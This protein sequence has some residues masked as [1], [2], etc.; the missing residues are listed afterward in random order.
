MSLSMLAPMLT[1]NPSI[2]NKNLRARYKVAHV[3]ILRGDARLG[4][5]YAVTATY[6]NRERS[7][8]KI[9]SDQNRGTIL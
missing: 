6:R 8:Q 5:R 2:R 9:F 3:E 4:P 7:M 1:S